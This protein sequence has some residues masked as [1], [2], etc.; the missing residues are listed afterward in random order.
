MGRG[1]KL[2]ELRI[3]E[4]TKVVDGKLTKCSSDFSIVGVTNSI[5]KIK[6]GDLYL[7]FA[8]KK[9]VIRALVE[10]AISKGAAAVM[11]T[12]GVKCGIPQIIV[13]NAVSS[14]RK[15]SK[16]YRNKFNI[17]VIAVTGSYGKTSTR[18]IITSVLQEKFS[19]HRT[20]QDVNGPIGVP[21][22]LFGLNKSHQLCI[23][24]MGFPGRSGYRGVLR[25]TA[26]LVKPTMGI[27]TN[28]GT[29]H[30]ETLKSKENVFKAKMEIT[31]NFKKDN[32][33]I[34]NGDDSYLSTIKNKP[35]KVIKTSIKGNGN[36]NATEIINLG[37]KGA[38]FKCRLRGEEHIF[39]INVPGIH[40]VNNALM[41]IAIGDIFNLDIEEIKNGIS[42]FQ[43]EGLR[44]D[45]IKLKKNITIIEDCFNANIDS[46]KS[47]IDVL[48]T[49]E[50]GRKIAV[51]GD[52][53]ELGTFSQDA[54]R[55]VGKY[56][57]DKCDMLLTF[58]SESRFIF[59][60]AKNNLSCIHFN[61]KTQLKLYLRKQM[62]QG[63]VILVK[64]S[65]KNKMEEIVNFL[66]VKN[67]EKKV[68]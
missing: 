24:E 7:S 2:E 45:I 46:M 51:L 16:Y 27:I 59:E 14:L 30:L 61:S 8:T 33:L 18:G 53:L 20:A 26:K 29:A 40:N 39:K 28:I 31:E 4:I 43:P 67:N 58:G 65:R 17:P 37:Q 15:L 38:E 48:Q 68:E 23:L 36:Y 54:H 6:K 56:L 25:K 63:D 10:L 62:K 50:G 1:S 57:V 42:N 34:V 21:L 22:T 60:E 64:G 52:M 55:Q 35:Y 13:N 66:I 19:I 5:S 47:S 41:A 44:M 32:I 9:K 12:R 11:V 3:Y 49:F